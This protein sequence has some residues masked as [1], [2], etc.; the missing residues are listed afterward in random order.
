MY[1]PLVGGFIVFILLAVFIGW[2]ADPS[3][4]GESSERDEH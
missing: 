4:G 3:R 1:W 2:F